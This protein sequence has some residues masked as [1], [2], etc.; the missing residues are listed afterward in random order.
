LLSKLKFEWR[1]GR[2][3][4]REILRTG[5]W[6]RRRWSGKRHN[7]LVP[8]NAR[9][10]IRSS[11]LHERRPSGWK[12]WMQQPPPLPPSLPASNPLRSPGYPPALSRNLFLMK[13]GEP[14]PTYSPALPQLRASATSF[15]YELQL[16][17]AGPCNSLRYSY[18][19]AS[20]MAFSLPPFADSAAIY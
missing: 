20:E 2:K 8:I 14:A 9:K 15:N 18:W 3:E 17:P 16:L 13:F 10:Q 6:G 1:A 5:P 19:L 7:M 4:G 11:L 12:L